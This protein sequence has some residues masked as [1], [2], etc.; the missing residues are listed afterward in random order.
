MSVVG[1]VA[2]YG[3]DISVSIRRLFCLFARF[4]AIVQLVF[5]LGLLVPVARLLHAMISEK[6]VKD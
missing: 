6:K 4:S 2:I 1:Y 3:T 5:V